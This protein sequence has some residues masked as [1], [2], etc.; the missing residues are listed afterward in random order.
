[1]GNVKAFQAH[2]FRGLAPLKKLN[3]IVAKSA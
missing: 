3:L 2:D 1:M